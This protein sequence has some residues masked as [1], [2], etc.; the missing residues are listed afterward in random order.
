MTSYTLF[1]NDSFDR[2]T[3]YLVVSYGINPLVHAGERRVCCTNL[4]RH[5]LSFVSEGSIS[6]NSSDHSVCYLLDDDMVL[7]AS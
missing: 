2:D 5:P 7:V 6:L 3:T 1:L 4:L